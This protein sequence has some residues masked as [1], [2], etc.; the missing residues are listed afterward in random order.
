MDVGA[1][2]RSGYFWGGLWI[3]VRI[4]KVKKKENF[5]SFEVLLVLLRRLTPMKILQKFSRKYKFQKAKKQQTD[6]TVKL[7]SF[8]NSKWVSKSRVWRCW[9]LYSAWHAQ[10]YFAGHCLV[11]DLTFMLQGELFWDSLPESRPK[12]TNIIST[13]V[14]LK[15]GRNFVVGFKRNSFSSQ[16]SW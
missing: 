10:H 15:R 4:Q 8:Q 2:D 14:S 13:A 16:S 3:V 12:I 1:A 11:H 6:S 5:M 9:L 7:K